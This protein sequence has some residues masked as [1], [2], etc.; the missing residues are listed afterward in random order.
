MITTTPHPL[1][2]AGQELLWRAW[3]R[4]VGCVRTD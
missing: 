2:V 1:D 3:N 4:N